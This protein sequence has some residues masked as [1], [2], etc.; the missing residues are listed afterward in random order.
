ML[1]GRPFPV[2]CTSSSSAEAWK[3]PVL[4]SDVPECLCAGEYRRATTN[5]ASWAWATAQG[6]PRA[7]MWKKQA[8]WVEDGPVWT[9]AGVTA[10][11]LPSPANL[12]RDDFSPGLAKPKE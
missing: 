5:K 11:T 8:R 3:D 4:S 2:L 7:I 12:L 6:D 1:N 9:S 10:G